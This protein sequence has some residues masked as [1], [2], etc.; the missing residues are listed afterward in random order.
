ML[1]WSVHW[2]VSRGIQQA[3]Y[4]NI[5]T[6]VAKVVPLVMFIVLAS[7]GFRLDV[8]TLDIWGQA[9]P[10]LGNVMDQVR[11]MMLVTV[12]VFIGVEGASIYSSKARERRD[13]GRATVLGFLC[14]LLLLVMV[15]VLSMGIMSQ[16]ELAGL[17]NPSMALVLS[18]VVGPWGD[19]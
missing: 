8:F 1:L 4:I 5:V 11:N 10:D 14:V 15:N 13:V 19:T 17:K 2:L 16:P 9:N 7:I 6:T 3:A 12:W 18:H